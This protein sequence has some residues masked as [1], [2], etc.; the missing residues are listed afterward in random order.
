LAATTDR[1]R[2]GTRV[3]IPLL[4]HPIVLAKELT[5]IDQ[6]APGRLLLGMGTGWMREEFDSVGVGFDDRYGRLGEHLAVMRGAW[7]EPVSAFSGR[8]YAHPEAGFG[9]QPAGGGIPA[10]VGGYVDRALDAVAEYGDGWAAFQPAVP[11]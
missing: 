11:G 7:A 4:R 1:I 8:Y 5:T 2:V 3:L 6:F 9:P 10:L